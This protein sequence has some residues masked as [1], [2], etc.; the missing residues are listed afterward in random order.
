MKDALEG[1]NPFIYPALGTLTSG[2]DNFDYISLFSRRKRH[3]IVM[4][5]A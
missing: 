4:T 1:S 5:Y 3:M 2:R